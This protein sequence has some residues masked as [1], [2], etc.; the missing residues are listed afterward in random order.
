MLLEERLEK[1]NAENRA[2]KLELE[3]ARKQNEI[4]AQKIDQLQETV[5]ELLKRIGGHLGGPMLPGGVTPEPTNVD[6]ETEMLSE[7]VPQIGSKRKSTETYKEKPS[8]PAREIKRPR[9]S[10]KKTNILEDMINKLT[11]KTE[12]MFDMLMTR[13][14]DLDAER[15]A[16]TVAK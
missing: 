4:S 9:P 12:R 5:N 13:F 1:C 8:S 6:E 3:K 11:D 15:K 2:L 10:V 16:Q 14:T 7:E